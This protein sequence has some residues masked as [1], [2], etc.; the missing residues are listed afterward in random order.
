MDS[1]RT[2]RDLD[3]QRGPNP[4]SAFRYTT[5]SAHRL[6]RSRRPAAPARGTDSGAEERDPGV[7]FWTLDRCRLYTCFRSVASRPL[8]LSIYNPGKLPPPPS[9]LD[10]SL[11][12]CADVSGVKRP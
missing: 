8:V 1:C 10:T 7:P 11:R 3:L 6:E 5:I 12:P 4:A 9:R 2:S